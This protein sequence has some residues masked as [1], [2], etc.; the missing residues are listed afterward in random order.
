[1]SKAKDERLLKLVRLLLESARPVPIDDIRQYVYPEGQDLPAFKRMFER[2]KSELR[3]LAI[4]LEMV[5]A[6]ALGQEGY[7]IPKG[8]YYMPDLQ[9]DY[10][11]R[12]ALAIARRLLA[13]SGTP[14]SYELASALAKLSA[15]IG[16]LG[17]GEPVPTETG[18][19]LAEKM[20]AILSAL[21]LRKALRFE[22]RAADGTRS[23]RDLH[24]YSVDA[25]AGR[26]Y[27]TGLEPE[28]DE[29]RTF[30]VS[31]MSR[32]EVSGGDEPDFE[33]PESFDAGAGPRDPW[34]F[35]EA[36]AVR[37]RIRFS[38]RIAWLLEEMK[39]AGAVLTTQDDGGAMLEMNV[40]NSE[41]LAA[42]LA[43]FG[44]D[45]ELLEPLELREFYRDWLER[46]LAAL[47]GGS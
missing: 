15:D 38:E 20:S 29:A 10:E 36:P 33:K 13:A 16:T 2:D 7:T 31:R 14:K 39:P 32:V 18:L 25:R 46:S 34:E 41:G 6:A 17:L 42:W 23:E 12:L 43:G 44:E 28:R 45:A 19:E 9:L 37:A 5:S 26:W 8:R 1:M 11:E 4:P 30:R 27:V 21:Y 24:P 22:Y 3:D 35:Y 40:R 47:G